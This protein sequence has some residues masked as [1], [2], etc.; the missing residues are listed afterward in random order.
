MIRGCRAAIRNRDGSINLLLDFFPRD[1]PRASRFYGPKRTKTSA[2]HR[3]RLPGSEGPGKPL[4]D[5]CRRGKFKTPIVASE[6][7]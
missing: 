4:L 7:T 1:L 5:L 2:P 3:P 6:E